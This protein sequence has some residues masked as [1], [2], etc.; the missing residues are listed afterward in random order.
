MSDALAKAEQDRSFALSALAA[1]HRKIAAIRKVSRE[2]WEGPAMNKPWAQRM[3]DAEAALV[4]ID[5]VLRA[6]TPLAS[7]GER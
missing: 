6:Q 2:Y 5:A 1:A 4:A 3:G 7:E